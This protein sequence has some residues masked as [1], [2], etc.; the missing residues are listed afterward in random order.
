MKYKV[1]PETVEG[2]DCEECQAGKHL[3]SLYRWTDKG[4][5]HSQTS[6][7]TYASAEECKR[8][9]PWMVPEGNDHTWE[10]GTPLVAPIPEEAA[11]SD[12]GAQEMVA[13]DIQALMKSAELLK[14]HWGV[15]LE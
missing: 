15:H 4:W 10:D 2:C 6:L 7:Q 11:H 13:L 8:R 1:L 14:K 9:H 3:Y 5:V 12:D